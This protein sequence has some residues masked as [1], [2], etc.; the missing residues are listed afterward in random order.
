MPWVEDQAVTPALSPGN[1]VAVG[2]ERVM[3]LDGGGEEAL[4]NGGTF[5]E[6]FV[7]VALL[8]DARA[9]KVRR[10]FPDSR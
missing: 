9:G 2:L 6:R 10:F 4:D 7:H 5:G 3:N 1:R 8:V